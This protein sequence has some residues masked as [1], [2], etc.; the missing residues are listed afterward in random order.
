M[1]RAAVEADIDVIM[2]KFRLR[3]PAGQDESARKKMPRE[4]DRHSRRVAKVPG[5]HSP[6]SYTSLIGTS[7]HIYA[8]A[9]PGR[10]VLLKP[11]AQPT[12]PC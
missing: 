10:P 7:N 9:R 8:T 12:G 11:H 5:P 3:K 4:S 2:P 6:S 1:K